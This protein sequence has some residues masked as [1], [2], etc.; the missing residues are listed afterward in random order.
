MKT[1]EMY[2]YTKYIYSKHIVKCM[3]LSFLV[4]Y[5]TVVLW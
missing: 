3:I 1:I 4:S 2:I 5:P